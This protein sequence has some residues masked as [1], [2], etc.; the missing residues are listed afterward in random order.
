MAKRLLQELGAATKVRI[1]IAYDSRNRWNRRT[2]MDSTESLYLPRPIPLKSRE[3][4]SPM[5]LILMRKMMYQ[6]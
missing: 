1:S 6:S 5:G 3:I 2:L 4:Y